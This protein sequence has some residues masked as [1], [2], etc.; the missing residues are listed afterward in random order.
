MSLASCYYFFA[1]SSKVENEFLPF[2]FWIEAGKQFSFANYGYMSPFTGTEV[3][4]GLKIYKL[5][6]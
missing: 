1:G 5:E 3:L 4:D 2:D 6:M